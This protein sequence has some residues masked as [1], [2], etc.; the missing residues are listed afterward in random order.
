MAEDKGSRPKRRLN[1]LSDTPTG[2]LPPEAPKDAHLL[3]FA[4]RLQKAMLAKGYTQSDL[5]REA[6]RFMPEGHEIRRD[7]VSKYIGAKFFP[8]LMKRQALAKALGV[9]PDELIPPTNSIPASGDMASL[10]SIRDMGDGT[11]WLRI[12]EQV[13]WPTALKV[14]DMLKG[15][16]NE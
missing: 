11:V 15:E 5:A 14:L 10:T 1:V 9:E 2:A 8:D 6:T 12:N 3:A 4:R 7:A 13:P 16:D